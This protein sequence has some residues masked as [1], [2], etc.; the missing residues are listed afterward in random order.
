LGQKKEESLADTQGPV[1]GGV[2]K[3][4]GPQDLYLALGNNCGSP[5][6]AKNSTSKALLGQGE[7]DVNRREKRQGRISS[8]E[9]EVKLSYY[10]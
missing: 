8:A 7:G 6:Q 4:S 3:N 2:E 10:R 5:A 1:R 9:I